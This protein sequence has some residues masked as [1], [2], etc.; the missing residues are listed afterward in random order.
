MERIKR[1]IGF[2]RDSIKKQ[3]ALY[4]SRKLVCRRATKTKTVFATAL[5]ILSFLALVPSCCHVILD[6]AIHGPA[7]LASFL[8]FRA[9]EAI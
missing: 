3:A 4:K 6:M 5:Y 1:A 9:S 8:M 7:M 2:I